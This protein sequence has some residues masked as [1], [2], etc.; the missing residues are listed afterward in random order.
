MSVT[1]STAAPGSAVVQVVVSGILL[2]IGVPLWTLAGI[3]VR[4][5]GRQSLLS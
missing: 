1:D 3:A 5:H 4:E 2:R